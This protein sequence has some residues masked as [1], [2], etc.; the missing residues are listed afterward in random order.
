MSNGN[1]TGTLQM[2]G[3]KNGGHGIAI[4]RFGGVDERFRGVI[5]SREGLRRS[6]RL[7]FGRLLLLVTRDRKNNR[8]RERASCKATRDVEF[9]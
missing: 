6:L 3:A 4:V 5:W 7:G 8:R 9:E 2:S 1:W